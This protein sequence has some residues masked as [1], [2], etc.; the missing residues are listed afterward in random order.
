MAGCRR[1]D[2]SNFDRAAGVSGGEHDGIEFV[3]SEVYKLLEAMAWELGTRSDDLLEGRYQ[4]LV[5][6]IGAAQED[7]TCTSTPSL[8]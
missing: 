1:L 4:D 5:R 2:G 6:R 7:S 3:D 8:R